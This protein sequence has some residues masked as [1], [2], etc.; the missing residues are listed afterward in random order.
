M[1]FARVEGGA[2]TT[3]RARSAEAPSAKARVAEEELV[4]AHLPLVNYM[5]SEVASRIPRH[6]CRDDLVSAGMAGLAQAAR[7]YDPARGISFQ[8]FASARIRGALLD[9][10]R[11]RDWAS[12]SV[13]AKARNVARATDELTAKLGRQPSPAEVANAM[14]S[15]EGELE[16]INNDVYRALVLNFDA[17]PIDGN[18]EEVVLGGDASPDEDILDNEKRSYLVAAVDHLPERLRRVVIGYFF[19][20]LP[21]QA[22]AEELGVTDSRISQM[23]AEALLLLKDAINAQLDPDLVPAEASGRVAKRRSTY[24]AEVA[25]HD[26]YR[27]RLSAETGQLA[28]LAGRRD[29]ASL[30]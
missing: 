22:L 15:T 8:R 26:D 6:V 16:A 10:L 23:R 27:R 13:R 28:G 18:A 14:G 21:M 25:A 29:L 1:P 3:T 19:E 17:L 9:E 5:V 7:A 2:S 12:R 24:F 20:E 11:S 4:R 30:A